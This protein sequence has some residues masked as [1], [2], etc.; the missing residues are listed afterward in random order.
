MFDR[1]DTDIACAVPQPCARR[2]S[3]FAIGSFA[4]S[5]LI[6]M[7]LLACGGGGGGVGTNGT[8]ITMGTVDG[9]GSVIVDGLQFD[10]SS[11]L[12]QVETSDP[13]DSFEPTQV[14]LGQRTRIEFSGSVDDT[15]TSKG[16]AS[17]IEVD[18][19]IIGVVKV[20]GG[21]TVFTVLGQSVE[22]NTVPGAVPVTVFEGY[23]NGF[24]DLAIDD[25]VEVHATRSSSGSTM[26]YQATRVEKKSAAATFVRLSGIVGSLPTNGARTFQIGNLTVN[27]ASAALLPKDS[28]IRVGASVVVFA[29]LEKLVGTTL[30]AT[31]IRVRATSSGTDSSD[32]FVSGLVS[33]LLTG[34][35][36]TVDGTAIDL[37][38]SPDVSG[39]LVNGVYVRVK[40]R[41]GTTGVFKATKVQVRKGNDASGEAK[42]KGTV[43]A[44]AP[45]STTLPGSFVVRDTLVTIPAGF[46]NYVGCS[47]DNALLVNGSLV[48]VKGVV[49]LSG[50][51][52]TQIKCEDED[53]VSGSVVS[54]TGTVANFS[55]PGK[56]FVLQ[57]IV[58]ADITV[59]Y[60]SST[61]FARR[62]EVFTTARGEELLAS[63]S[64]VEVEGTLTGNVLNA[65]KIKPD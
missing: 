6:A 17:R 38:G 3:R 51:T 31:K 12:V 32:D 63:A 46:T 56:S 50:V 23:P 5:V 39:T 55:V 37:T 47:T 28:A 49:S 61:V 13:G 8:G 1:V 34:S 2:V 60:T 48:E 62:G 24:A 9:F 36:M 65:Q 53:T 20:K 30:T 54:R 25:T 26:L 18:P 41:F 7:T 52:A 33:E 21:N 11:A 59:R 42:L 22:I 57:N 40:G 29:P 15:T 19:S 35:S 58:G 27:Y 43:Q 10:N 64:S 44:Y 14:K 16:V 4:A 45:A